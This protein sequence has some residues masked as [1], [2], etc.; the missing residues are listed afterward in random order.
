MNNK[1][2]EINLHLNSLK[3]YSEKLKEH[4]PE[5]MLIESVKA[6][7]GLLLKN[8]ERFAFRILELETQ[9]NQIINEEDEGVN[10]V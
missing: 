10:E 1:L 6:D 5:K 8:N 3:N 2:A 4:S 7:I 9:I